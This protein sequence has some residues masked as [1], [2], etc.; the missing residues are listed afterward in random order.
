MT[1]ASTWGWPSRWVWTGC[2]ALH[3]RPCSPAPASHPSQPPLHCACGP[4]AL[5]PSPPCT[6]PVALHPCI[7]APLALRL[8]P[9][10]PPLPAH[11]LPAPCHSRNPSPSPPSSIFPCPPMP[12]HSIPIPGGGR[13]PRLHPVHRGAGQAPGA[14]P[15]L[16]QPHSPSALCAAAPTRGAAAAQ[17]H[18]GG[19]VGAQGLESAGLLG[20]G[21]EGG[22]WGVR[23]A[24]RRGDGACTATA[25]AG[26]AGR[27]QPHMSLGLHL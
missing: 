3:L 26:A 18:T 10:T 22:V 1:M 6:A 23:G 11:S 21:V 19:C 9:C 12:S 14:G 8:W 4:A 13:H 24:G 16:G 17:P 20:A 7:P 5:H 15:G 25:A 27:A 2:P